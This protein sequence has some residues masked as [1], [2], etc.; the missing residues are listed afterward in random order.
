M[1]VYG[2][3]PKRFLPR[4]PIHIRTPDSNVLRAIKVK[5]CGR[6]VGF[7][8]SPFRP[9]CSFLHPVSETTDIRV[10]P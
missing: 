1:Y 7:L 8:R 2:T 9:E 4:V 5:P 6:F 3:H 10:T